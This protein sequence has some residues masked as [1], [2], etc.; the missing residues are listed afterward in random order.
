M[1]T[2]RFNVVTPEKR[3]LSADVEMVQLNLPDGQYVL[4]ADHEP[5]TAALDWGLVT[6]RTDTGE[7]HELLCGEGFAEMRPDRAVIFT[8]QCMDA[9]VLD[10]AEEKIELEKMRAHIRFEESFVEHHANAAYLAR[11]ITKKRRRRRL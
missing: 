6:Y 7:T 9:D 10:R 3:I 11:A 8:D 5:V 2:F 4:L 1:K